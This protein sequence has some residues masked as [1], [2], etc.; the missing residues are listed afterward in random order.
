MV[1]KG[2]RM[3]LVNAVIKVFNPNGSVDS[4]NVGPKGR[5]YFDGVNIKQ[6]WDNKNVQS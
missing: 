4:Y 1:S 5:Y 3:E 6:K 2:K